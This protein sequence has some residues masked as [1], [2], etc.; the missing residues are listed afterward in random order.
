MAKQSQEQKK[1]TY[2][3][4]VAVLGHVDH[5]KTTLLD[6]IR[7]TNIA[8]REHGGITQKIGASAIEIVHEGE[9]R[10]I[11]FIDTPGH[12]AFSNMRGRGATASD[13]G[14]LVVSSVDGVMP[15]TKESIELLKESQAP[16]IV[17]LTKS[18]SELKNPAK[19]KQQLLKEGVMLEGMGGDIPVLEVSAKTN[20]NIKELLDL[21]LLVGD[22]K[23]NLQTRDEEKEQFEAIIIESKLDQRSGPKATMVVKKGSISVRD[24]IECQGKE[25]KIK[26][27]VNDRGAQLQKIGIGEAAEVLGFQDVPQVGELVYKKGEAPQVEVLPEEV[28]EEVPQGPL[29]FFNTKEYA[30]SIILRADTLGSL[31]AIVYS[32]PDTINIVSKKV[33]E[34]SEADV[35]MAKSI[36][37][38]VIGFNTKVRP[39]IMKL[40]MEEKILVKNYTIIYE[41]I[42]ELYDVLEGKRLALEVKILGKAKVL[43]SFPFEKTKVLGVAVVEGRIAKGD[44]IVLMHNDE[45]IGNSMVVSVRHGKNVISK[46]EQGSE[47]GIVISPLLDFTIG[48]MIVSQN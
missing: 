28:I 37:A 40:A 9:K 41:L 26:M 46:A 25:A 1:H 43:A 4:V 38:I 3:P 36:G 8:D 5:G 16:Y 10:T 45:E 27:L 39:D 48:D 44:R 21:I 12:E 15:Q 47:A 20:L 13:I 35:L 23:L 6:T 22:L 19:V 31:E 18:D 24:T 7:K 14:I 17:V 29:D 32:L 33:G 34:M 2:S 30:L 42:Q 11:T